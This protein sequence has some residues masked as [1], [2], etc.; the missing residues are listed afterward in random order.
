MGMDA[1]L[2]CPFFF[3]SRS[4][5]RR[6]FAK[7]A[8]AF[9]I[10]M[11]AFSP[12]T[13]ESWLRCPRAN[14]LRHE[15]WESRRLGKPAFARILGSGF[16][17]GIAVY[18]AARKEGLSPDVQSC[19]GLAQ[20]AITGDLKALDA[21]GFETPDWELAVRN[22][23]LS[24]VEKAITRYAVE[25]CLPATWKIRDVELVL[26]RGGN[27]RIDLGCES[28]L[29]PVVVDYKVK[30]TLDA[31]Y[32]DKERRKWELSEQRFHYIHFYGEH[33]GR[34]VAQ[35]TIIC[36][37]LDPW[38]IHKWDF[39]ANAE[40]QTQW[41]KSREATWHLIDKERRYELP[42]QMAAT[43]ESQYGPCDFQRAC[44]DYH[45]DPSLMAI[46]YVKGTRR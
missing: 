1:P 27:C 40:E 9:E 33:L 20:Q 46:D 45:L 26:P 12:S 35:F 19:V 8:V 43:H 39:V 30:V 42:V 14:Q 10:I 44:F 16:A 4:V 34:E 24:R 25:D 13:T 6:I 3:F 18:N 5:W 28:D 32:V 11:I 23:L 22:N 7:P 2:G 36:I 21:A 41:L 31:R 38:K 17:R 15:G 37:V 29:G